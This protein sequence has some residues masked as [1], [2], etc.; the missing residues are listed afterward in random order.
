AD[1]GARRTPAALSAAGR[2]VTASVAGGALGAIAFLIAVG[3]ARDRG[4]TEIA[5]NHSLGV[6]IGGRATEA[7]TDQ[8]LGVA[9]DTAGPTGFLWFVVIC[10]AFMA[11]YAVTIH[12]YLRIHWALRGVVLGLAAWLAVSLVYFPLLDRDPNEDVAVSAF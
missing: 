6:M 12:R 11:L 10:V 4:Y 2:W 3:E 9:G 7:S 1:A 8:A 5:F